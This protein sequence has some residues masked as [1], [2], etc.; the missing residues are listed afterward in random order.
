M[1]V[2]SSVTEKR[3]SFHVCVPQGSVRSPLEFYCFIPLEQLLLVIGS[4]CV[5]G[6]GVRVSER[7]QCVNMSV[8]RHGLMVIEYSM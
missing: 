8:C 6:E 3:R 5:W 7:E 4:V 2:D 1:L